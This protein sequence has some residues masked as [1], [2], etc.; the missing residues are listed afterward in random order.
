MTSPRRDV[1]V[2][3]ERIAQSLARWAREMPGD[4]RWADSKFDT[5][6]VLCARVRHDD[7]TGKLRGRVRR[8]LNANPVIVATVAPKKIGDL[9]IDQYKREM[10]DD[11]MGEHPIPRGIRE[12]DMWLAPGAEIQ[13]ML[14]EQQTDDA[15]LIVTAALEDGQLVP[16]FC[17]TTNE[18]L[19]ADA[20]KGHRHYTELLAKQ[21]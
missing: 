19:I 3:T 11:V 4:P 18:E 17:W 14:M 21:R 16:S 15:V 8:Y 20:Q 2:L 13:R 9:I 7:A 6:R 1:D 5:W 10:I 12:G